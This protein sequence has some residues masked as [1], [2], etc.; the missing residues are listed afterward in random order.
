[1]DAEIPGS[2]WRTG[3]VLK[4]HWEGQEYAY[5]NETGD[6]I[7]WSQHVNQEEYD[8]KNPEKLGKYIQGLVIVMTKQVILFQK[9]EQYGIIIEHKKNGV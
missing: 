7:I 5:N 2:T 9:K 8:N 6:Y 4:G 3:K 1:M